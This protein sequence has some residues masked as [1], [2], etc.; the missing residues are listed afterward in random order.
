MDGRRKRRG[1]RRCAVVLAALCAPLLLAAA[2][3]PAPAAAAPWTGRDVPGE[4]RPAQARPGLARG[5]AEPVRHVL[6]LRRH[7]LARVG[8]AARRPARPLREPHGRLPGV[9]PALRGARPQ[10]HLDGLRRAL[11]GPGAGTRRPLSASGG[12]ARGAARRPAR[13][14]RPVPAAARQPSRQRRDQVG[15][16]HARRRG[17]DHGLRA[18]RLQRGHQRLLLTR[19]ATSTTT[20]ASSAGTT[21]IRPGASCAVRPA[22]ARSSSRTAGAPPTGR[23]ATSGS[24]TTTARWGR[25]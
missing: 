13:A 17:R 20:S 15:G 19:A 12:V 21:A 10:H 9:A 7:R 3:L 4:V 6:D 1:T 16:D 5:Q 14:G 2:A 11:G 23:A 25:R 24:P 22:R 18:L 8:S